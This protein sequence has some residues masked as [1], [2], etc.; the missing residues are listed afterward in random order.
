MTMNNFFT[1]ETIKF[2]DVY[3]DSE[4]FLSDYNSVGIPAKIDDESATTLFYLLYARY[5]NSTIAFTDVN[6]FKY[7]LFS[8]V[9][10]YG[11]TWEEKLKL[12]EKLRNLSDEDI[13]Q[14]GKAIYNSAANPSTAPSTDSDLI[15]NYID[16]QNTTNYKK[17]K[18]E[19]IAL[20]WSLLKTDVTEYFLSKFKKLFR[21]ILSPDR[22]VLYAT[23]EENL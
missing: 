18:I 5:G 10:M 4:T 14:G 16:N 1:Y 13:M 17:S 22:P 23:V 15:L 19:G 21:K 9:Y 7:N 11:P 8:L 3:T 20:K 6:Q 2:S 12:Q